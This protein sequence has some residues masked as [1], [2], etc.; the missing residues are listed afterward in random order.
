MADPT[1]NNPIKGYFTQKDTDHMKQV[2]GGSIAL[3]DYNSV[4]SNAEAIDQMVSTGQMPPG[5]PWPQDWVT[6]FETWA[7]N[8]FP[9]S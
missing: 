9:E 2:S 8:G 6:N 3:D 5:S 7:G 1:W 4:V